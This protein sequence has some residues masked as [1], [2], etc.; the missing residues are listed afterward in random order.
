MREIINQWDNAALKFTEGQ[1]KSEFA[2]SNKRVVKNR[3]WH[4]NGEKILEYR[5]AE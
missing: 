3:F 5:K 1:E 2:E 4:F